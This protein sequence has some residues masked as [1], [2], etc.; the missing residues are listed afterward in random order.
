M[1]QGRLA[2]VA[3]LLGSIPLL[4]DAAPPGF[5]GEPRPLQPWEYAGLQT[6]LNRVR[7][8]A[9]RLGKQNA[10]YQ[11]N[12]GDQRKSDLVIT[13]RV[14]D[15]ALVSLRDG[16]PTRAIPV[17]PTPALRKAIEK[18]DADWGPLRQLAVASPFDYKRDVTSTGGDPL[19]L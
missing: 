18:L 7:M 5:A 9:Q 16:E 4:A 11:L 6:E 2:L 12:L 19:L 10:L 8:L 3:A 15:M 13:A 14:I 17:P 1:Y